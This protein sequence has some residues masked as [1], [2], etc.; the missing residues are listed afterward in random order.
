MV[1]VGQIPR[2]RGSR[3]IHMSLEVARQVQ[4]RRESRWTPGGSERRPFWGTH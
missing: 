2:M 4:R 3:S 1:R